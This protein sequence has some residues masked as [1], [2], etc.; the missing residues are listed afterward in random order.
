MNEII[1]MIAVAAIPM[2]FAITLH[3]A[4]HGYVAKQLGDATAWMMGRVTANPLKHID[5][6]GT[7]IV[8][9]L[10]LIGTSAAGG[11]IIFGW[12]KPVPVRFGAL[13]HPKRDMVWVSLAGP[14]CNLLQAVLW[15][16]WLKAL[17]LL[18][19]HE[20]FFLRMAVWGININL[21][22][23]AFNLIPIPPLDGGRVAVGLL[24]WSVG[25]YLQNLEPYGMWIVI[26]LAFAGATSIF[27][28]PLVRFGSAIASFVIGL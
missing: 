24:P 8:P 2:I 12:A 4:A 17:L 6:M 28:A 27:T 7:I 21:F 18:G 26:A 11:G 16:V 23:M 1:Q 14:G 25:R 9:L 20:T 3:E 10:M 19:V 15:A 13:R 22:L 5:P